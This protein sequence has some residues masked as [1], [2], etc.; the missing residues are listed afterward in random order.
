MSINGCGCG[1]T[2]EQDCTC[3]AGQRGSITRSGNGIPSIISTDLAGDLYIE[4]DSTPT[5]EI[6]QFDGVAWIDTGIAMT[7]DTGAPGAAGGNIL[8]NSHSA[9]ATVGVGAY[10]TLDTFTT[11]VGQLATNGDQLIV[12]TRY[13]MTQTN[14]NKGVRLVIG[15]TNICGLE[16]G[17]VSEA[18]FLITSVVSR[19]SAT[20]IAT[21]SEMKIFDATPNQVGLTFNSYVPSIA[22]ADL[23]ANALTINADGK[24][25]TVIGDVV[26]QFLTIEYKAIV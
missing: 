15:G 25:F 5:G 14:N 6:W 7:G 22:V 21:M 12:T 10:A 20:V 3:E 23:D 2:E 11:S 26:N 4:L 13:S 8:Y 9:T 24:S 17:M 1:C 16:I 18:Y 19:I